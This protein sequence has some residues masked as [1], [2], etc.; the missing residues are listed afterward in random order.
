MKMLG[1]DDQQHHNNNN[2]IHNNNNNVHNS[3]MMDR[4]HVTTQY[5]GSGPAHDM[6]HGLVSTTL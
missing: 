1:D 3:M 5:D 4:Y 2:N 6:D